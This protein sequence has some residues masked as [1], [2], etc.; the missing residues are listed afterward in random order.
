MKED[1]KHLLKESD[2]S[3]AQMELIDNLQRLGLRYF[4]D[5]EIK[6]VLLLISLDNTKKGMKDDLHATSIRFR[7]LRQHGYKASPGKCSLNS[8]VN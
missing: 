7:L 3:L 2:D 5:K 1:V 6:E 4:F 8:L